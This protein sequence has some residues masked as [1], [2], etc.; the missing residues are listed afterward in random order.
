MKAIV[1]CTN[2]LNSCHTGIQSVAIKLKPKGPPEPPSDLRVVETG[3]DAVTLNWQEGFDGGVSKTRFVVSYHKPNERTGKEY[4]CQSSNPCVITG[5][6]QQTIYIFRVS[7]RYL[8]F[9][10]GFSVAAGEVKTLLGRI[11]S[12]TTQ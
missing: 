2:H 12:S 6:E 3:Y 10:F 5:L 4:D 7:D 11:H 9:I 8:A 1:L